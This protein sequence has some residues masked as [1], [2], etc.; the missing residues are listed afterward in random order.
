MYSFNLIN[1]TITEDYESAVHDLNISKR[2]ATAGTLLFRMSSVVG[3]ADSTITIYVTNDDYNTTPIWFEGGSASI[4]ALDKDIEFTISKPYTKFYFT[5][6]LNNATSAI[7]QGY[8]A[9]NTEA[10]YD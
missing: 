5:V 7:V 4:T 10:R 6:T 1:E 2:G 9:F 8:G 3:T